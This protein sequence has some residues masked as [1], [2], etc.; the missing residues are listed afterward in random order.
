MHKG[1]LIEECP[2]N[3]IQWIIK[4][5]IAARRPDLREA[6]A[7]YDLSA[8]APRTPI[9]APAD[10]LVKNEPASSPPKSLGADYIIPFGRHKGKRLSEIPQPY[11]YWL[12][13]NTTLNPDLS[14]C[15]LSMGIS[16][17]IRGPLKADWKPPSLAHAPFKFRD[18]YSNENLWISRGDAR[19][20]FGLGA[21]LLDGLP[22]V[23]RV[24][25]GAGSPRF[26]LYHVWDLRRVMSS[27]SDADSALITFLAKNEEAMEDVWAAM[28][29]GACCC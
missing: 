13:D 12:T 3:Y 18:C 21:D 26:W 11:L 24:K 20:Y 7:L 22:A 10:D 15:L 6:L 23:G 27:R 25:P 17:A 1:K 19:K 14:A 29:L 16:P 2:P 28:G 9:A 5:D 4:K 8:S